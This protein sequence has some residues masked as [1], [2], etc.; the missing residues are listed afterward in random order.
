MQAGSMQQPMGGSITMPVA[1]PAAAGG[2]TIGPCD[3]PGCPR[4]GT[5]QCS[6]CGTKAYCSVECQQKDWPSHKA[7]CKRIA[8]ERKAAGVANC[9]P[10]TPA[11]SAPG[12]F[13]RQLQQQQQPQ[14]SPYGVQQNRIQIP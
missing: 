9:P 4:Q 6:Q 2:A 1:Q 5:N 11:G 7:E 10:C 3:N 13:V 8:A 14:A 12:G